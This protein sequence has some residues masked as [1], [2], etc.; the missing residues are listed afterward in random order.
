[1]TLLEDSLLGNTLLEYAFHLND[2]TGTASQL[3]ALLSMDVGKKIASSPRWPKTP[4][5]LARELRRIAPQLRIHGISVVFDRNSERRL[6]TLSKTNR[7]KTE[8]S[9]HVNMSGLE[10]C[11]AVAV[12]GENRDSDVT[13]MPAMS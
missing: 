5:S 11:V 12:D 8:P 6:I 3:L 1:L 9:S 7:P 10:S 4:V 2:W 13:R